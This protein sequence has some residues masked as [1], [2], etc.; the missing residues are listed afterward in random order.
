MASSSPYGSVPAPS[1]PEHLQRGY[2]G[3]NNAAETAP[4]M[5]ATMGRPTDTS[6]LT[7]S[8]ERRDMQ[9]VEMSGGSRAPAPNGDAEGLMRAN[10]SA[11]ELPSRG[12]TLKKKGSLSRKSSMKRSDS[13]KSTRTESVKSL[14]LGHSEKLVVGDEDNMNNVYFTPVPT[15][16]TPTEVLANRFQAW[17]KV[18]KDLIAYYREIQSSYEHRSKSIVKVSNVIGGT[19][20]PAVF[21]PEGSGG[22][23]DATHILRDLHKQSIAECNKA[24]E[25]E[26]DVILSLT[27]LRNDLY[28]KIKEIRGLSGDFKNA[29]EK[30]METTRKAV[31]GLRDALDD[32]RTDPK[33]DPFLIKLA[34][35]RQIERQ[36]DEE[37]YLHRAYL[38]LE[39]SGRELE[40]IVV[41]EIQKS[42]NALVGILRREADQNYETIERLRSGPLAMPRDHEW[43]VFV[44]NDPRFVDPRISL[45]D[46]RSI[47]Y[48]GKY[49][50]A[51]AEVRNGMLERKS[52]YLKS[53]TAGWYVLSPTHLH[54]F[55][56]PDRIHLQTPGMSLYL[57]EQKLGT[58]SQT[59]SSSHKFIL[60][61]RQTGAMHR[62]HSWVF[63]AESHETMMAWYEDIKN[64]T[65]KTGKEREAFV[66]QH[67]R[68]IS[69]T[70]QAGD[71]DTAMDEDEADQVP[72]SGATPSSAAAISTQPEPVPA[73]RPQ[74]GGRF[75]SDLQLGR[76]SRSAPSPSS[77]SS[78]HS[79]GVV[80]AAGQNDPGSTHLSPEPSPRPTNE[81]DRSDEG[82]VSPVSAT[83]A[84]VPE[85]TRSEPNVMAA[86][87]MKQ[88]SSQ[89]SREPERRSEAVNEP[90][91][92]V[93]GGTQHSTTSGYP[94]EQMATQPAASG[95]KVE[96]ST[97]N[98]IVAGGQQF[99]AT[100]HPQE[101]PPGHST[102]HAR[103]ESTPLGTPSAP[104]HHHDSSSR[105]PHV[106]ILG[107]QMKPKDEARQP[108]VPSTAA[109][110]GASDSRTPEHAPISAVGPQKNVGMEATGGSSSTPAASDPSVQPETAEGGSSLSGPPGLLKPVLRSEGEIAPGV[111]AVVSIHHPAHEREVRAPSYDAD[112]SNIIR[113]PADD[114]FF[115]SG[116][117]SDDPPKPQSDTVKEPS[118]QELETTQEPRS[119]QDGIEDIPRPTVLSPIA[120]HPDHLSL[121]A[122]LR[123]SAG[124]EERMSSDPSIT[125]PVT[126]APETGPEVEELSIAAPSRSTGGEGQILAQRTMRVQTVNH[127]VEEGRL[128]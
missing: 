44:A 57:P 107:G 18:L 114:G 93:V 45:R 37:N 87:Y 112:A 77:A 1:D 22:L 116:V 11:T 79:P 17:R 96:E 26:E 38:N 113:A 86:G 56:S 63:R 72:Y 95:G 82:V 105:G 47:E 64:L 119:S 100:P 46:V 15:S 34:V 28:Q 123:P 5:G 108:E 98:V 10:S 4:V 39:G 3:S 21:M 14:M 40:S 117:L 13:R 36:I 20:V 59:G 67:A 68:S 6:P 92:A 75:P 101:R 81:F 43:S 99:G 73:Q 53:Y 106:A 8:V 74:P 61:G 54:E 120:E 103:E 7:Q 30:E 76:G 51:A 60:K 88:A 115:P 78:D 70:S 102:H 31:H 58:H 127:H 118:S 66:R 55:K 41:G 48:P 125:L 24:K 97:P 16:G 83:S 80:A 84:A 50:P 49:H 122:P 25:I 19:I 90:T 62:G 91:S 35:E 2:G 124:L 12:G 33:N 94:S 121:A 23:S 65:E 109:G 104:H 52:K 71:S 85:S 29:V 42:Y 89:P 128:G 69:G 9:P 27:S 32:S 110:V 111:P 126:K